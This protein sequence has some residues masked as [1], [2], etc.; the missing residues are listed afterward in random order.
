MNREQ[1]VH[2]RKNSLMHI[3]YAERFWR[4]LWDRHRG[5]EKRKIR[6][7]APH[8]AT[9]L[10][11]S[12]DGNRQCDW[13]DYKAEI[14]PSPVCVF[15]CGVPEGRRGSESNYPPSP[16]RGVRRLRPPASACT[17]WTR[18]AMS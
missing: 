14:N 8:S 18:F 10:S 3:K 6:P 5:C 13:G 15:Y 9:S 16:A 17:A 2:W 12:P 1:R 11:E 4:E 7:S